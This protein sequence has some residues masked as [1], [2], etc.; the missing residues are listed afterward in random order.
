[1]AS[2]GNDDGDRD[3]D[4]EEKCERGEGMRSDIINAE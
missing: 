2:D 1:M 4:D 3:D